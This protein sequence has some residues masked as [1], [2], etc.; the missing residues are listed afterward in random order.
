MKK[1]YAIL[2]IHTSFFS[3]A[4]Q[5]QQTITGFVKSQDDRGIE[6]ATVSL[7]KLKDSSIVKIAVTDKTG[8]FEFEKI[9]NDN[10]LLKID[11]LGYNKFLSKTVTFE[12]KRVNTGDLQ[13][14]AATQSLNDVN[15]S[16]TR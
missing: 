5:A 9:K 6:A 14:T 11:A 7:L 10:Y 3:F 12:G 2:V 16:A 1:I 4:A 13:L 8:L 15:V